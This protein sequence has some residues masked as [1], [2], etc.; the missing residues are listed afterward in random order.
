M[1]TN[2]VEKAKLLHACIHSPPGYPA[3][4]LPLV[5]TGH[6]AAPDGIIPF[7]FQRE[8][9]TIWSLPGADPATSIVGLNVKWKSR[10]PCS[11]LIKNFKGAWEVGT[12][13]KGS[14][15]VVADK[16][17]VQ[18][19]FHNDINYYE[20]NLKKKKKGILRWQR[21]TS[22]GFSSDGDCTDWQPMKPALPLR[23]DG[24]VHPPCEFHVN[25][26]HKKPAE[27]VSPH[28]L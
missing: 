11:K 26:S 9:M 23:A 17:Y 27:M 5:T 24:Y 13:G 6:M 20:L 14:T 28:Y 3:M 4:V 1:S 10:A 19:K 15:C 8:P 21:I 25:P 18:L 22:T 12:G 16:I 2:R 7:F